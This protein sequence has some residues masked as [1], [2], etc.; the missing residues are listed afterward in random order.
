MTSPSLRE[1]GVVLRLVAEHGV[2]LLVELDLDAGR[3]FLRQ[4]AA[5]LL[6]IAA[7]ARRDEVDAVGID[8]DDLRAAWR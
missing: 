3:K 5:E 6:G 1:E 8:F 4:F 2:E 7:A